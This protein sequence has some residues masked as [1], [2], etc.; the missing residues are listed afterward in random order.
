[1]TE[2]TEVAKP[3]TDKAEAL[4]P[5]PEGEPVPPHISE[6]TRIMKGIDPDSGKRIAVSLHALQFEHGDEKGLELY[7]KIARAGGFLDPNIESRGG[8]DY[9][10]D[11]SLDDIDPKAR[12]RV[13]AILNEKE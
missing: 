11:L 7:G 1:M 5:V 13:N 2:E 4:K 10:P 3:K 12:E 6:H 9:Y 8:S